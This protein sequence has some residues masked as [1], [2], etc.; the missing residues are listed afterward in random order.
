MTPTP[1]F[2]QSVNFLF[3]S[4]PLSKV[5]TMSVQTVSFQSFADQ[6]PGTYVFA[7]PVLSTHF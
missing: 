3:F 7:S 2:F 6:K 1:L 4:T 5:L